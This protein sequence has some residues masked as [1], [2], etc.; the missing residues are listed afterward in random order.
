MGIYFQSIDRMYLHV[1]TYVCTCMLTK[2]NFYLQLHAAIT[3]FERDKLE[4]EQHHSKQTQ[5]LLQETNTRIARA[6]DEHRSKNRANV[7]LAT[8]SVPCDRS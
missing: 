8:Y 1:Y 4:L 3:D 7:S 5:H 6:N 2:C